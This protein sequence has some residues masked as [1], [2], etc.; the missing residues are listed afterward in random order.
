MIINRKIRR[1]ILAVLLVFQL[2][3]GPAMAPVAYAEGET[4]EAGGEETAAQTTV[5]VADTGAGAV[6]EATVSGDGN[7]T[8]QPA[9][10]AGLS[11]GSQTSSPTPSPSSAADSLM[12]E[13]AGGEPTGESAS[14]PLPS[15]NP[16]PF[17][18]PNFSDADSIKTIETGDAYSSSATETF[19][20]INQ[21]YIPGEITG[22]KGCL[23]PEGGT[24]CKEEVNINHQNDGEA[25]TNTEAA[26][27]T[28][29]STVVGLA[30]DVI[31]KT[32]QAESSGQAETIV[33]ANITEMV[34]EESP[35]GQEEESSPLKITNDNNGSVANTMTITADT[36]NNLAVEN[37]GDVAINS[38]NALAWANLINFLN[39]NIV[40]SNFQ[41]LLLDLL[42]ENGQDIDLNQLWLALQENRAG[43]QLALWN[44]AADGHSLINIANENNGEL[45]NNLTVTANT[46]GNAAKDNGGGAA[47]NTG[48]A[49]A[50]ANVTN[51][52][53]LNIV[54][55]EFMFGMIN[56]LDGTAG[57]LI[58][59]RPER[60]IDLV[61][62]QE[63]ESCQVDA[64]GG[65]LI[66]MN[67]N[68]A[69]AENS[70]ITKAAS[71]NNSIGGNGG[72]SQA[73][74]GDA[75][76]FSNNLSLINMDIRGG[77][78]FFLILNNL[79]RWT[80]KIFGWSLPTAAD[81]AVEGIGFYQTGSLIQ[82]TDEEKTAES[83]GTGVGGA[84]TAG[85]VG[86]EN[87]AVVRNNIQTTATTGNNE[88]VGNSG[89]GRLTTGNARAASNLINLINTNILGGRWFMGIVNILGNWAG[90]IIYAYPDLRVVLDG[91]PDQVQ[92]GE[93]V[94]YTINYFNNGYDGASNGKI[95]M[96][97]PAGLEY[98]SDSSGR[99]A[100][101]NGSL[102]SWDLGEVAAGQSGSFTVSV[103]IQ[104]DFP[105]ENQIS[106]WQRIIP[107]AHAAE[108]EK[109]TPVVVTA[110]IITTDPESGTD[111]KSSSVQTLVYLPKTTSTDEERDGVDP[112][113]PRL[114]ITAW[115]NVNKFVYP[116]D[117][118]SFEIIVKNTGESNSLNTVMV[119]KL[120]NGMP[121]DF[122][123]FTFNL[124]TIPA[125]R[126]VKVS[127]GLK[128][129]NGVEVPAGA[130]HTIA[131]AL[132]RAPNGNE[133]SSGE[134][135]TDFMVKIRQAGLLPE[136]IASEDIGQTLGSIT[137]KECKKEDD[138]FPY[139]LLMVVSSL[140]I[141][142]QTGRFMREGL[143][144]PKK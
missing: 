44:G 77:N 62:G 87:R 10:D 67:D 132:G 5:V 88:I 140:W 11:A 24:F 125:G 50:L 56:I 81:R 135:R 110:A 123:T 84:E 48:D 59:P 75:D 65:D 133:V 41:L 66:F 42:E 127:F 51:F 19:V 113:Q 6:Q 85:F 55:A 106:F 94:T 26:S 115:N 4:G 112:R 3:F 142:N 53:N 58:L 99:P 28:G 102:I 91:N 8:T 80:G 89:E 68:Q 70:V 119:Q 22:G 143:W 63:G 60:F 144:L 54:G 38:G 136:A 20:G 46:G 2:V 121:E 105:F 129:N 92:P 1:Q 128:L 35:N 96:I 139:V 93:T 9:A 82:E 111:N 39:T 49:T 126:G 61:C 32:G 90:N 109:E 107:A 7:E 18:S 74:T 69:T 98:I 34:P 95:I 131:Q 76:S 45:D 71:G 116:G 23:P 15:P 57:D 25:T 21:E 78:W 120:Y 104:P 47:I 17:S 37:L 33:N 13:N 40:G 122:G 134:A 137:Q 141:V 79:G 124:G 101:V 36:G 130:Y 138:I 27:V 114:E 86:N 64:K 16:S 118:V 30:G 73:F 12:P 72:G 97:L 29:G 14:L 100:V 83:A 103:R 52:V 108:N 43:N 117:T 31:I